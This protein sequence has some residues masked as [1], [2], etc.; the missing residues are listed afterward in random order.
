MPARQIAE[1]EISDS[2]AK[3]TFDAISDGLEH[4]PNLP[5]YSLPQDN[6]KPR[7]RQGTKP[8]NFRA[9]AIKKNSVQQLRSERRVPR[10]IQ[11]D[12]ILLVDLETGVGETLRQVTVIRQKQQ[13]LSLRVQPSDREEVG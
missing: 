7:R 9:L 8:S 12:L 6:V 2:N 5:I 3:K 10:P 13:T 4:A 11:R 1:P